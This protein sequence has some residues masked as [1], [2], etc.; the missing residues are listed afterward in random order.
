MHQV[1]APLLREILVDRPPHALPVSVVV[2]EQDAVE[3]RDLVLGAWHGADW[4]VEGGLAAGERVIVEGMQKAR[5]GQRVT[6][7]PATPPAG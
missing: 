3:R 5:P 7:A 2:D 1:A 6:V 4:I